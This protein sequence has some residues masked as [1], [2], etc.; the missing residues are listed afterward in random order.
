[1]FLA[2]ASSSSCSSRESS[3]SKDGGSSAD[4]TTLICQPSN[5]LYQA[6]AGL[7]MDLADVWPTMA[8]LPSMANLFDEV[9]QAEGFTSEI[10]FE[11][12]KQLPSGHRGED[13][14]HQIEPSGRCG[15]LFVYRGEASGYR[16]VSYEHQGEASQHHIEPPGHQGELSIHHGKLSSY[17][18]EPSGHHGEP[19]GHQNKPSRHRKEHSGHCEEPSDHQREPSGYG[20]RS[21]ELL[22]EEKSVKD[23]SSTKGKKKKGSSGK[24]MLCNIC[25][26]QA[27]HYHHG[28]FSCK[29]CSLF[30]R[31]AV[32]EQRIYH[33][34]KTKSAVPGHCDLTRGFYNFLVLFIGHFVIVLIF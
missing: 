32:V 25:G 18:C 33:C 30:F 29:P 9:M 8:G 17:H 19:S 15:K 13:S 1:M 11:K 23:C 20:E 22:S 3:S 7:P 24:V 21:N 31:R 28:V 4:L 12:L 26:K 16:K 6:P 5:Y 27:E 14:E 2:S 34:M 10:F